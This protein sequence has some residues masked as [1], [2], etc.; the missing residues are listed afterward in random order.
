MSDAPI[1]ALQHRP[2]QGKRMRKRVRPSSW[3]S[4]L[5]AIL[6]L[7]KETLALNAQLSGRGAALFGSNCAGG[8][9]RQRYPPTSGMLKL[10]R[11]A[12]VLSLTHRHRR[13]CIPPELHELIERSL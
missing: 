5:R 4:S 7:R 9:D 11:H 12:C 8:G 3:L 2:A 13:Y 6:T 10:Q 1:A